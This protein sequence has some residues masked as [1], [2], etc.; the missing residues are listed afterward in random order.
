MRT[1]HL[2]LAAIAADW[3]VL[4]G[5]KA[6][7]FLMAPDWLIFILPL[8]T[9]MLVGFGVFAAFVLAYLFLTFKSVYYAHKKGALSNGIA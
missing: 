5:A 6:V 9:A 4:A 8:Y 1:V 7:G 3:V 2:I